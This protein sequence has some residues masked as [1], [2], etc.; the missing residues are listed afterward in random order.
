MDNDIEN[1]NNTF[2]DNLKPPTSTIWN[3][4]YFKL[5][6]LSNIISVPSLFIFMISG[7]SLLDGK[8]G[9]ITFP[10]MLISGF[11]LMIFGNIFAIST[12]YT[13]LKTIKKK[14][15]IPHAHNIFS[16]YIIAASLVST[17]YL[18]LVYKIF[19]LYLYLKTNNLEMINFVPFL[20]INIAGFIHIA[21][22]NAKYKK[23]LQPPNDML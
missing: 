21:I 12:I 17:I 5:L 8:G 15:F 3:Q 13:F 20:L 14:S 22:L 1:P 18:F 23:S 11:L 10:I 6:I 4:K 9:Y 19:D 7:Q 2:L 16:R